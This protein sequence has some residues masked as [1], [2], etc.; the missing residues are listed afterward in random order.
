MRRSRKLIFAG[1]LTAA[2]VALGIAQ[3]VVEAKATQAVQAPRFEVDPF[4]PK[5][6]PNGWVMG[7]A[8]GVGVDSRDHVYIIHRS[9]AVNPA[10][11]AAADA[12][13]PRAECC[14]AA[15]PVL[16]F[17]PEGNL[18]RGWGGPVEGASYVW[19]GSNH[20]ITVDNM[21]NVW[22]GGNGGTDS[23]V[24]KFTRDGAYIMTIGEPALGGEGPAS[25]SDS[26][27]GRV[28]KISFD[29]EANE[30][31]FADGYQNRR[32][33]VVDMNTGQIKRF[34]GAYGNKPDDAHEYQCPDKLR[35][36][37]QQDQQQPHRLAGGKWNGMHASWQRRNRQH[38]RGCQGERYGEQQRERDAGGSDGD[39]APRFARH[40]GQEVRCQLGWE[41]VADKLRCDFEIL[42]REQ[43]PRSKISRVQRRT[44]QNDR[45]NPPEQSA[46]PGRIAQRRS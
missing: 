18:V 17:D 8:I 38:R 29:I 20:G 9:D 42:G 32:V 16:E 6:L 19:P 31:Y 30:A 26:R 36:T 22:I 15:P 34:W 39:G 2:V 3:E 12:S 35:D 43:R 23:H 41:K 14:K 33:A 37:S 25:N 28:A 5:P 4:W 11:E 1:T 24:L 40:H 7:Q 45:D 46:I 13:P 27:F 21:D 44:E 10:T